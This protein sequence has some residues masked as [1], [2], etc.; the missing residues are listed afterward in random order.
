MICPGNENVF[1]CSAE[2][3]QFVKPGRTS[4]FQ[5]YQ[6]IVA[7]VFFFIIILKPRFWIKMYQFVFPEGDWGVNQNL[8]T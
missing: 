8:S 2:S 4:E 5:D 1:V 6:F 7:V 3:L